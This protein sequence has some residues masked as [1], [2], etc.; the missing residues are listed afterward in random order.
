MT[1]EYITVAN[2]SPLV[3]PSFKCKCWP[4]T[5]RFLY[6][7]IRIRA[8]EEKTG[9][10][11]QIVECITITNMYNC[12]RLPSSFTVFMMA[13]PVISWTSF[14]SQWMQP[15]VFIQWNKAQAL[16]AIRP[17]GSTYTHVGKFRN[18][19]AKYYHGY[20]GVMAKH[21]PSGCGIIPRA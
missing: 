20:L 19:K 5:K 15:R 6:E 17:A 1:I 13:F 7:L 11:I 4:S 2:G 12:F 16:Y 9:L 21:N 8:N 14:L 3:V 10:P 18:C